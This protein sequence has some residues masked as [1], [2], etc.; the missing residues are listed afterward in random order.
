MHIMIFK[1]HY[2]GLIFGQQKKVSGS[3]KW[4]IFCTIVGRNPIF[5]Y[6]FYGDFREIFAG[7]FLRNI[8]PLF[9]LK[10]SI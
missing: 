4:V 1:L 10:T 6:L 2:L 7:G 9:E 5:I 3:L 8:F